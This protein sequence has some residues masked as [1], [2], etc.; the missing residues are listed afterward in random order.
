MSH[1]CSVFFLFSAC[2]SPPTQSHPA[3][4]WELTAV[5][6]SCCGDPCV[7]RFLELASFVEEISV[8]NTVRHGRVLQRMSGSRTAAKK[9]VCKPGDICRTTHSLKAHHLFSVARRIDDVFR[10]AIFSVLLRCGRLELGW[11][12]IYLWCAAMRYVC[13]GSS[14]TFSPDG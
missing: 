3:L 11:K 13:H 7:A 6:P 9:I 12:Q 4:L 5:C 1:V 8:N 10:Y 14:R 2:P